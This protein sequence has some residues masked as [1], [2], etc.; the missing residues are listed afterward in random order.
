[1]DKATWRACRNPFLMC[2]N[3]R[4]LL[5]RRKRK[6]FAVACCRRLQHL[7]PDG[8]FVRAIEVVERAAD[9]ECN[10]QELAKMSQL[11][12]EAQGMAVDELRA[13]WRWAAAVAFVDSLAGRRPFRPE[14]TLAR[15][16]ERLRAPTGAVRCVVDTGSLDHAPACA[17]EALASF[18]KESQGARRQVQEAERDA[19]AVLLRDVAGYPFR[20]VPVDPAW[21]AWKGGTIRHL[22]AAIYEERAFDRMPILA[23]ALEDAGCHDPDVLEHCRGNGEHV[24]GCWVVDLLL[25][26]S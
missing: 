19:Q 18:A 12:Q 17:I 16:E 9:G 23:D 4:N 26:R 3:V 24:L 8:V 1:M 6:L 10:E 7:L 11:L 25:G 13:R 20:N 5:S 14:T 2:L 21:P 22:A 15:E